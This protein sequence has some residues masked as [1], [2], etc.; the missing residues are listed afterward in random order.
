MELPTVAH[1]EKKIK[2]GLDELIAYTEKSNCSK[3]LTG[4]L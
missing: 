2:G 3:E 4:I 1:S